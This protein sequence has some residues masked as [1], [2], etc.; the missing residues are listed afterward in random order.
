MIIA[1]N[2]IIN[3][4]EDLITVML[5]K[6]LVLRPFVLTFAITNIVDCG[7]ILLN[8]LFTLSF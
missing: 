1:T 7:L 5:E 4:N 8:P 3:Y 2:L 6:F